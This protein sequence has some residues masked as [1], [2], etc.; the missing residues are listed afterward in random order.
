MLKIEKWRAQELKLVLNHLVDTLK[1]G[2]SREWAN[3]F[4]HYSAELNQ[5]SA[6]NSF[7]L[8]SFKRLVRNINNCIVGGNSFRNLEFNAEEKN[9]NTQLNQDLYWNRARLYH[10]LRELEERL[11]EYIH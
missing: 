6:Y 1:Q 11:T 8:S 3:V 10:I 2:D 7:D 5:I 4:A 9:E